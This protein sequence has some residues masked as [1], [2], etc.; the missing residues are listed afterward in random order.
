MVSFTHL[1]AQAT[2]AVILA[3]AD[4]LPPGGTAMSCANN[5]T[6]S[7]GACTGP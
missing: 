6:S 4:S 7:P 2:T 5:S 1:S 3:L